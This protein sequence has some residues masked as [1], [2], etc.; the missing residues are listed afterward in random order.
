[1]N[2]PKFPESPSRTD[3]QKE[4][5]RRRFKEYLRMELEILNSPS[6]VKL[7]EEIVMLQQE[8]HRLQDKANRV[9]ALRQNVVNAE[10]VKRSSKKPTW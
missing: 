8:I 2:K 3:K 9:I 5:Y 7:T 6:C 10:L 1:M 4:E